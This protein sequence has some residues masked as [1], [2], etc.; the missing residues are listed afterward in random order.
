MVARLPVHPAA[1]RQ[2]AMSISIIIVTVLY[3]IIVFYYVEEIQCSCDIVSLNSS[4]LKYSIIQ[5]FAV[6]FS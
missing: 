3:S 6:R 1:N 4:K 2:E 5:R